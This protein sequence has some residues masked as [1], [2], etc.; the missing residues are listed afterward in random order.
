MVPCPA[1]TLSQCSRCVRQYGKTET[2]AAILSLLFYSRT[3]I[4]KVAITVVASPPF[5]IA[6]TSTELCELIDPSA[7]T[8][9]SRNAS[10]FL[11][12]STKN[13]MTKI[14]ANSS[15]LIADMTMNPSVNLGA[16]LPTFKT[17]TVRGIKCQYIGFFGLIRVQK[18][19][20][21]GYPG[22]KCLS[23]R[24]RY[25]DYHGAFFGVF[26][27]D[28]VDPGICLEKKEKKRSE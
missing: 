1:L 22:D 17:T 16:Y 26:V 12:R 2:A 8:W 25:T 27:A 20:L 10:F 11:S 18:R 19:L 13:N 4:Y 14:M 24:L 5:S 3:S 23:K 21:T 6:P 9:P 15:T 7:T 28:F